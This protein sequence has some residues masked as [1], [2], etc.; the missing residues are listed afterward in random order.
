MLELKWMD[1]QKPFC[2][3][4]DQVLMEPPEANTA[5]IMSGSWGDDGVQMN[6][7]MIWWEDP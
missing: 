5:T 4:Y 6:R 2:Q 1:V 7:R 3:D